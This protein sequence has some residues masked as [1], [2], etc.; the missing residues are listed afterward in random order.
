MLFRLGVGVGVGV[1]GTEIRL[2]S[3]ILSLS[4]CIPSASNRSKVSLVGLGRLLTDSF[5]IVPGVMGS[6]GDGRGFSN[7]DPGGGDILL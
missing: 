3:V 6:R 5:L 7:G 4:G 1:V 2:G